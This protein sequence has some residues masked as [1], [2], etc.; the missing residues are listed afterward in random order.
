MLYKFNYFV[1]R[2]EQDKTLNITADND[3]EAVLKLFDT[4]G[5]CEFGCVC[6]D[7]RFFTDN[8]FKCEKSVINNGC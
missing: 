6:A 3:K 2:K 1:D 8:H 5:V 7:G 4:I